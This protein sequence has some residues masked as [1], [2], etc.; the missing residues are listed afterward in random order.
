MI[1]VCIEEQVE[2]DRE[3]IHGELA[4]NA[5]DHGIVTDDFQLKIAGDT[6]FPC[7]LLLAHDGCVSG[8]YCFNLKPRTGRLLHR[9]SRLQ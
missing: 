4:Q 8:K 1:L 2:S 3:M 5:E 9:L 7:I 6:Q